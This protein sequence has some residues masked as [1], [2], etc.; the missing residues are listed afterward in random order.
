[1]ERERTHTRAA[2]LLSSTATA[3]PGQGNSETGRCAS[4]HGKHNPGNEQLP[5]CPAAAPSFDDDPVLSVILS[6][7]ILLA[8]DD[9]ITDETI[10]RQLTRR[11]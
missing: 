7:A 9:K 4:C 11:G 3:A 10:L 1:M 2:P 5:P 8:A 6:K